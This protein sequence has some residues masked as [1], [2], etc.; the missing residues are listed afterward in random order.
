MS[1]FQNHVAWYAVPI[2]ALYSLVVVLVDQASAVSVA[3]AC[4][5]GFTPLQD[6][7]GFLV[8][9]VTVVPLGSIGGGLVAWIA[10]RASRWNW[11]VTL[12]LATAATA[13]YVSIMSVVLMHTVYSARSL[14]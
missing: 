10:V 9:L 13:I 12:L 14:C 8:A 6:R 11:P 3:E 5:H 1:W 2:A 7:L 4:D